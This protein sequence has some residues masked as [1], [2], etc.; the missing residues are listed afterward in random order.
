MELRSGDAW[1][2]LRLKSTFQE[3][4]SNAVYSDGKVLPVLIRDIGGVQ[5][6]AV[7]IGDQLFEAEK[8]R[9]FLRFERIPVPIV[10]PPTPVQKP[11][12]WTPPPPIAIPGAASTA[13]DE[14]WQ[15]RFHKLSLTR[16]SRGR[17]FVD[18]CL[19][20]D[21]DSKEKIYECTCGTCRKT[22]QATQSD[23][24]LER[25]ITKSCSAH[26]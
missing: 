15:P 22:V 24:L 1:D 10:E 20:V 23:L 2:Y 16:T 19:G 3:S 21:Y 9:G 14:K 5:Q 25:P 17:L 4:D 13:Q 7:E 8:E 18:K 26:S 12:T 11:D 6:R